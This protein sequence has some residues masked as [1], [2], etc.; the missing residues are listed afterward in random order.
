[1]NV[2]SEADVWDKEQVLAAVLP[3]LERIGI[4]YREADLEGETFVPGLAIEEGWVVLDRARLL[5]PGDILHEAG[6]I[7]V[8]TP[9]Q[10]KAL[11]HADTPALDV[12][13]GDEIAAQLW[14]ALAAHELGLP[15]SVVF[16]EHGY[17]SASQWMID[18]FASGTYVGLPLLTWM[19]ITRESAE[20]G[21]PVV[22]SWL[23]TS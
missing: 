5:Y 19:G 12:S 18:N 21:Q 14:S 1:M 11:G 13:Q 3:F 23:R 2:M 20:G 17:R 7:A 6:H 16:H 22:V 4:P 15:L 9:D 10:R 8:T